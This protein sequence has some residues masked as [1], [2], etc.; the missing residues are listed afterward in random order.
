[1]NTSVAAHSFVRLLPGDAAPWFGA[2]SPRNQAFSFDVIAGRFIVLC[3]YGSAADPRGQDALQAI[4]D[5]QDIFSNKQLMIFS[6]SLDPRD[7]SENRVQELGPA[8]RLFWDFDGN[9]SRRYGALPNDD[10]STELSL[11]RPFWI[12]L[13]PGLRVCGVFPF[14]EIDSGSQAVFSFL[15]TLPPANRFLGFGIQAPVLILPNVFERKLCQE[16]ITAYDTHGGEDSGFMRQ[17]GGKTVEIQDFS[18]KRRKDYHVTE[19]ALIR[20]TQDRILR[21]IVPEIEKVHFFKATRMERYLVGCYAVED[22]AHFRPHRDNRTAGTAHR[23]FAVSI[24]LNDDFEGGEVSFP[25][26]SPRGLKAPIGGA[27]VFSC[28]LLHAVSRVTKGRRYAF[29]PFLYD[30]DAAKIRAANNQYV[31]TS[32]RR[33]VNS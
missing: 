15:R 13:D 22:E 16:L 8:I 32:L 25:E 7:E 12:V 24:N 5:N 9:I 28:S 30:E 29:L 19:P 26:Y 1:M 21:R 33:A 17:I 6:V 2:R 10:N 23:R 27:V 3:F 20:K 11:L 4:A 14:G 31:E 18:H